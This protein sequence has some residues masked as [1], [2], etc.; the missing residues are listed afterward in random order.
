MRQVLWQ[1]SRGGLVEPRTRRSDAPAPTHVH[2]DRANERPEER[3]SL[4]EVK[5]GV[6]GVVAAVY[7]DVGK[8]AEA[9]ARTQFATGQREGSKG[10]NIVR[11]EVDDLLDDLEGERVPGGWCGR[12]VRR[13]RLEGR[14]CIRAR[15]WLGLGSVGVRILGFLPF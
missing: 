14:P 8:Q 13:S 5:E 3:L 11:Q 6:E 2:R 1:D 4:E 9:T 15:I 10:I 7:P 12:P